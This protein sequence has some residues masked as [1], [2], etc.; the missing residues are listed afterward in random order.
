MS[1]VIS[2]HPNSLVTPLVNAEDKKNT[3]NIA[4]PFQTQQKMSDNLQGLQN[5]P[6]SLNEFFPS[7]K[8]MQALASIEHNQ[9]LY[10]YSNT[11]SLSL[12]TKEGD[13]VKVDF[14]QLYAQFQE[15]KHEQLQETGLQGV[16]M[17]ESKQAMEVTAFEEK[18]AFSVEGDLNEAELKAIFDVFEKVGDLASSFFGGNIEEAFQKAVDM[19]ID[20]GQLQS[21]NLDLQRIEV[22]ASSY[23]QAAAYQEV[24]QQSINNETVGINAEKSAEE[25]PDLPVYL[26]T[27]Q[28]VVS[29]LDEQFENAR[30]IFEELMSG[31]L[32]QKS[33][34]ES[35]QSDWLEK[36]QYFHNQLAEVANLDAVTLKPSGVEISSLQVDIKGV[37]ETL[38]FKSD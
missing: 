17:F 27:M 22:H 2:S 5:N 32:Q 35:L 7:A 37:E 23:Q 31:M 30:E 15:Y 12:T 25:M 18:F 20:M 36:L 26:Q 19:D 24:K 34:E 10:A 3:N 6:A 33:P 28:G 29:R 21:F 16:R 1:N 38:L 9:R 11:M 13:V 4:S 8:G 14:M